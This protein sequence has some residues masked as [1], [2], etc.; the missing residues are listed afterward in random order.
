MIN[1][2]QCSRFLVCERD[3]Q[4]SGGVREPET[5]AQRPLDG[6]RVEERNFKP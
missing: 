4:V 2:R 6:N 1:T 3:R 5:E